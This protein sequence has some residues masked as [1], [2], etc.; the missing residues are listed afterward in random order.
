VSGDP[1]RVIDGE[2]LRHGLSMGAAIDALEVA[3]QQEDPSLAA[4]LRSTLATAAGTLLLMPAAGERGVGV[5]LVTL[6]EFN[7]QKGL[8]FINATYV[9]FDPETQ[10]PEAV[11][12][13]TELTALRTAAV[14]GLATKLLARPEAGRLVLFGAGAQATAHLEAMAEV[15]E[16]EHV[17]VVSRSEGRARELVDRAAAMGLDAST[18]GQASVDRA[19]LICTCTTSTVSVFD[20]RDLRDGTHINAIGAY[21]PHQRELDTETVRRAKVVVE[22]KEAALA[23]AGDLL[24]PIREGAIGPEHIVA[25]LADVARNGAVRTSDEDVTLFESVGIAFEDLV[26]ARAALEA[27]T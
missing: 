14:S 19:D 13:G 18:G 22:T 12:D 15:R 11:I 9:L 26:V 16:L 17:T 10:R 4:P 3:F 25:D 7:P 1:V 21:L 6:S 2:E 24:I 8:P 5:K 20:G 27:L 23:E